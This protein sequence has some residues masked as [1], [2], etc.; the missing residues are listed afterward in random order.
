MNPFRVFVKSYGCSANQ[1]DGE[2][3]AGCLQHAGFVLV[4]NLQSADV[5]IYNCCAVKG[6]TEDRMMAVVKRA[7]RGKKVIVAGC[8]PVIS[9]DR[10]SREARFDGVVGPVFWKRNRGRCQACLCG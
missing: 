8:L 7:P 10:L 5:V 6:P 4:E 2:T 9:F 3:L 1:A